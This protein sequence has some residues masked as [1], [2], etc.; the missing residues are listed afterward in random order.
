MKLILQTDVNQPLRQVAAGF[1]EPLLRALAPP[2]PRLKLLRYD[3]NKLGNIVIFELHFGITKQRW[4][5]EIIADGESQQEWYFVDEG[6]ELPKPLTY[7]RHRHRLLALPE[8]GTRI[9]D[10]IT[11]SSGNSLLN[12]ILYPALLAQ[13]LY[14][15]P[16]YKKFFA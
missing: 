9:V 16:V 10:D 2:F 12:L 15:K 4:I 3:G 1:G 13:F 11:Y 7:W 5:S 14:R 8:G 6:R